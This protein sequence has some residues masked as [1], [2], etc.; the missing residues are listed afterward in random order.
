MRD[1]FASF[2]ELHFKPSEI[3]DLGDQ[4]LAIG[5]MHARGTASGVEIDSPWAF[6]VRFENRKAIWVRVYT[7]VGQALEAAGLSQ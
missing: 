2:D 7:Q 6:L 5:F 4:L 1:I 3:R